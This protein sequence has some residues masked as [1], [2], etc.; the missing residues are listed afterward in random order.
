MK[1]NI[2]VLCEANRDLHEIR[3][4]LA[5]MDENPPK[6]FRKSYEEF[7][8]QVSNM[9]FIFPQYEF[10]PRYRKAAV[11]FGYLIFYCVDKRKKEVVI[12]RVLNNK[13]NIENLL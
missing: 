3:E 12:Y 1:Y 6:K 10:N 9:P 13:Q 7:V 11:E 8:E 4:Y 5:N 2:I